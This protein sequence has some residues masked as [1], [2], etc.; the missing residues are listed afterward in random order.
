MIQRL[1]TLFAFLLHAYS[2][3][4]QEQLVMTTDRNVYIGGEDIWFTLTNL[5][6]ESAQLSN[7][8]KVA[9][10]ELLNSTNEPL[11]QE[12]IYL[13]DGIA[14]SKI[15]IP[16]TASTGNYLIRAYTRWMTNYSDANYECA[17][18]S[19]VNPFANNALPKF[20]TQSDA[21]EKGQVKQNNRMQSSVI[22]GLQNSYSNRQL[23]QLGVDVSE[24][25]WE[26]L[27]ISVVKSCLYTAV[28]CLPS[29]GN[30]MMANIRDDLRVPEHQGEII[31]GKVT[32]IHTGMPIANEKMMLSFVGQN[33][34]LEFSL[35][36]STGG[37]RYQV[38]RFGEQEMV[39]QPYSTDTTKLNYKVTLEDNFSADYAQYDLPELVLDSPQ[40]RQINSAIVNMQINTIYSSHLPEVAL[41]DS[42]EKADAFYGHPENTIIIDKYIELP[43]TEEVIREIVPMAFLRKSEGE[44]YVKVFEDKSMYPKEGKTMAFVDGVPVNE[45]KR[46]LAISPEY[47]QKIEVLNLNYYYEDENLGRLLLFY[48]R[49]GDMGNME[50]DNRIFRQ[51]HKGYLNSFSYSY[52]DYTDPIRQS[53]RLA[54]YRNLLYYKSV[55]NLSGKEQLNFEFTTGDDSSEYTIVLTGMTKNGE[56]E[57]VLQSFMVE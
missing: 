14:T 46:I 39:I 16:D 23:V 37:F 57:T 44:Y 49:N 41:A 35:T 33:P 48:T 42:V 22:E 56:K 50:F 45:F 8:S 32:D 55:S 6:T 28:K 15:T 53:S 3:H 17:I 51:V 11:I 52:P 13:S 4:A 29:V 40:V 26:Y 1:I 34:V 21:N 31:E 25:D 19:V 9:Y 2:I 43:T 30:K 54:D 7:V 10:V 5:S 47:L 12:K 27:N 18:V 38:N 36:D 20:K 24:K